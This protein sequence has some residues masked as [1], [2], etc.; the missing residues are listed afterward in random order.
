MH[1]HFVGV[2]NSEFTRINLLAIL[3]KQRDVIG[4]RDEVI[5]RSEC[6]LV[7]VI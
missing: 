7:F 4:L 3:C 1:V 6:Y 2:L 5:A